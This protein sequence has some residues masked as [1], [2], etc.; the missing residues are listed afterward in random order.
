MKI[1]YLEDNPYKFADV[2]KV[3]EELGYSRNDIICKD[4]L[5]SGL[6]TIKTLYRDG[7]DLPFALS[8]MYYP[9][10]QGE[11][12]NPRAGTQFIKRLN[13]STDANIPVIIISSERIVEPLAAACIYYNP[14]ELWEND[15]KDAIKQIVKQ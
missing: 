4:T 6:N 2:R 9:T 11:G 3:L 5:N 12:L 14:N 15:L 8:D 10:I 13:H 1:V 7:E